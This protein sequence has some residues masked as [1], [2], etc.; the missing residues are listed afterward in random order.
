[1][2]KTLMIAVFAALTFTSACGTAQGVVSDVWGA[3]KF[4]AR[5]VGGD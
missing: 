2:N 3:G 5:Q 1:M 4:V